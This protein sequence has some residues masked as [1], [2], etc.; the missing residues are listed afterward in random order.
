MVKVEV[1]G[2]SNRLKVIQKAHPLIFKAE[3]ER[4][5]EMLKDKNFAVM[6]NKFRISIKSSFYALLLFGS[7]AKK[8]QTKHSDIDLMFICP[9]GS[10]EKLEK[11]IHHI[12]RTMPLPLHVLVFSFSIFT[13]DLI[14]HPRS[15][16]VSPWLHS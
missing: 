16:A 3:Y 5:E 8:A 12:A 1:F 4:R 2:R 15:Y 9:D 7:Y 11:E 14:L 13:P 6:F 10:E